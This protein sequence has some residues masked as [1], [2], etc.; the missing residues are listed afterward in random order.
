MKKIKESKVLRYIWIVYVLFSIFL[1]IYLADRLISKDILEDSARLSLNTNWNIM[2]NDQS[3]EKVNLEKFSFDS[4]MKGDVIVME[5]LLPDEWKFGQAVL[6]IHNKHSVVRMYIDG[7]LKY[8]YGAERYEMN[9]TTGS[10][11]LFVNFYD[12]YKGKQMKLEFVATE[13]KAFSSVDKLWIGEWSEAHR[14]I[15]TDNRLPM[16]VGSFLVVLGVIMTIILAFAVI[17]SARYWKIFC[18]SIFSI[19]IGLWTLCYYN[20]MTIFYIP[21]YSISLMEYMALFIAPIPIIGYMYTY[22]KELNSKVM[23]NIYKFLYIAQIICTVTTIALHT[24][25]IVHSVALLPKFQFMF[26]IHIIFF[27]VV[28]Q[29]RMRNNKKMRNISAIGTLI[30]VSCVFYELASYSIERYMGINLIEIKG[31]SSIGFVAFIIILILDLYQRYTMSMMEEHEKEILIKRAYMDELTGIYNRG[32]CSDI[33]EKIDKNTN[34]N[35]TI[36]NF[37]LNDLK[38]TNDSFGHIA[39]D[40][41]IKSAA[42]V[43][44]RTFSDI[45]VVGRMGGDEFIAII[46]NNDK[47]YIDELLEDL[48]NNIKKEND[49]NDT[50]GLSISY[51][52]AISNEL[53]NGSTEKIYQLADN[54][55]YEYKKRNKTKE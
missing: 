12:D 47:K 24:F 50:L 46:E 20:V 48:E 31:A 17:I 9:K 8:E 49:D 44:E 1:F 7:E 39:G 23:I 6:G 41:L 38:K 34:S 35:Y 45:G 10:G 30:V 37:D 2:I 5:T 22:V 51:G 11:Y 42:K 43:L 14:Y 33:M 19:C 26:I 32:Y 18:L 27:V 53:S 28:L 54:R 40:I 36:I 3:Y 25:D 29:R 16:L 4:V 52:Y 55:M 21:L 15:I 13:N